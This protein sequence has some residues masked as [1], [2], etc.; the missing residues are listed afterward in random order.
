[1]LVVR[2]LYSVEVRCLLPCS[3]VCAKWEE[4]ERK[5]R[6]KERGPVVDGIAKKEVRPFPE[7]SHCGFIR[8]QQ[9]FPWAGGDAG[10]QAGRLSATH[11]EWTGM[12]HNGILMHWPELLGSVAG[13][14]AGIYTRTFLHLYK[15][16]LLLLSCSPL[17]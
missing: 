13:A 3:A 16:V 17:V 7:R 12:Y 2:F 5:E 14:A 9:K 1:M 15:Y 6:S 11:E 10:A 8:W 4:R